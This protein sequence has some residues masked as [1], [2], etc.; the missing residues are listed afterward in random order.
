MEMTRVMDNEAFRR[1][2]KIIVYLYR[3]TNPSGVEYLLLQRTPAG[4]SGS[5]WQTVVGNAR[6]NEKLIEA[7]CREVFEETG[8]TRLQGIMAIGY[9][10]SFDFDLPKDT[11]SYAPDV[12]QICN[13]VFAAE[14][15]SAK[16]ITLSPEHIDYG[17][18]LYQDALERV[19][20]SEEKEALVRLQPM[21]GKFD[22]N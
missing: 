12:R 11:S 4:R 14:V 15:V 13:T 8:L 17:W 21:L 5:I 6:W 20:W 22:L 10:F 7:A 9:A 19:H 18:F 3:R 2:D 1:P 16:P